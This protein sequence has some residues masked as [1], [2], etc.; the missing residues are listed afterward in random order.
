MRFVS[1]WNTIARFLSCWIRPPERF[2]P[3]VEANPNCTL[4]CTS[5]M[6]A[7]ISSSVVCKPG[8]ARNKPGCNTAWAVPHQVA[9]RRPYFP[10]KCSRSRHQRRMSNSWAAFSEYGHIKSSVSSQLSK[11]CS[12]RPAFAHPVLGVGMTSVGP[13]V[14]T[15]DGVVCHAASKKKLS[16][17]IC[18]S[19][20]SAFVLHSSEADMLLL[21]CQIIF[22]TFF[23]T[24][25]INPRRHWSGRK[26]LRW[27]IDSNL[28]TPE[29]AKNNRIY[30]N[31][32][33]NT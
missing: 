22:L 11:Q 21:W 4:Y 17:Y 2:R 16:T 25:K 18:I 32:S 1:C 9:S 6:A 14:W 33:F 10:A 3:T 5:N 31:I 15:C 26:L 7:S 24:A 20:M 29:D 27:K 30:L 13:I 19:I 8:Q 28:K 12:I 23:L